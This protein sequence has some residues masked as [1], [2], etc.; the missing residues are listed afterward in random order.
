M[1]RF[2]NYLLVI[3]GFAVAGM[4]G[5]AFGTG[6]AQAVVAT[7]VEVVNPT[8]SPV[9][10]SPVNVTDPGR[11]AYQST[12]FP[13]G[14]SGNFQCFA[15]FPAVP[16]GHRLVIQHIGGFVSLTAQPTSTDVFIEDNATA[17]TFGAFF[18]P[19]NPV[20]GGFAGLFDQAVLEYVDAGDFAIVE[21][22]VQ[23]NS[24]FNTGTQ[25][26]TLTGYVLDCSA[27]P[28]AAIAP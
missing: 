2:K 19:S 11:I 24:V 16:A 6:T 3:V 13:T 10:T 28:C 20:G 26:V 8:T 23:G 7:L 5:A 4:I 17:N 25:E 12:V 21:V 15:D 27:A 14:C 9:P 18:V 22:D 1:V